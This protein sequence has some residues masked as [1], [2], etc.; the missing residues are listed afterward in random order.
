MSGEAAHRALPQA[1]KTL[2]IA[3]QTAYPEL[4]ER[5]LAVDARRSIGH[6]PGAL[7]PKD[8]KGRS[9][10]S[11]QDSTPGGTTRQA[12]IGSKSEALGSVVGRFA[13]VPRCEKT[14]NASTSSQRSF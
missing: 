1:R 11:F 2:A 13:V 9:S 12:Y 5:L 7:V 8:I 10:D 6:A 4:L 14:G 3:T